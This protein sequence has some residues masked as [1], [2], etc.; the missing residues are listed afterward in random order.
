MM[1]AVRITLVVC[2][3]GVVIASAA[4]AISSLVH[5]GVLVTQPM[6]EQMRANVKARPEPFR[7]PVCA[8]RTLNVKRQSRVTLSLQ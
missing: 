7:V 4:D 1:R 8:A 3:S 2:L 6:L 5:P